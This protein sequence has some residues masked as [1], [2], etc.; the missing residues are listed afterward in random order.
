MLP[1]DYA[2]FMSINAST[3][4]PASVV[5]IA[6][7]LSTSLPLVLGCGFVLAFALG[8][9][10]LKRALLVVL[11]SMLLASLVTYTLRQYW[12]TARPAQLGWGLQ[13][14]KHSARASFPSMHATIGFALAQGVT[15]AIGLNA[16]FRYGRLVSIAVW[17]CA[18]AIAWSRICLGVHSPSDVMA[19]V[20]VGVTSATL[21][22]LVVRHYANQWAITGPGRFSSYW[23]RLAHPS[24]RHK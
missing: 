21:V 15:L 6:R 12:P 4:T 18:A 2:L 24:A 14:I 19:G 23:Y 7:W 5:S 17:A 13:W 22:A 3:A 11:M 10:A 20:L 1:F 8:S 16:L 9:H